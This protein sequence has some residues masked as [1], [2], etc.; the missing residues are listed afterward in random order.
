MLRNG[1]G[2]PTGTGAD[3][4]GVGGPGGRSRGATGTLP[5]V[6]G[7]GV[8]LISH[9]PCGYRPLRASGG[10]SE[11]RRLRGLGSLSGYMAEWQGSICRAFG[12]PTFGIERAGIWIGAGDYSFRNPQAREGRI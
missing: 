6:G 4:G 5:S 3:L 1:L 10:V 9:P 12:Y 11:D 2:G 8:R 7:W